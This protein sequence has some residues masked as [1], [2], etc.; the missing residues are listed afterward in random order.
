M[1]SIDEIMERQD[2]PVIAGDEQGRITWANDA[3]VQAFG[4]S[5]E[6]LMGASIIV[7]MPAYMHDAHTLGFSRFLATAAGRVLAQPLAL[8]VRHRSGHESQATHLI[9]AEHRAGRW[10]FAATI[11]PAEPPA[12]GAADAS[13][14]R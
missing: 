13:A 4:W 6:E 8:P 10:R 12:Q 3:F 11:V 1:M 2:V 5:R 7:I 9:V 14:Q